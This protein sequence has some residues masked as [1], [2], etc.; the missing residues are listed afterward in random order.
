MSTTAV[1]TVVIGAGAAG[2]H[3]ARLLAERAV[4]FE[5]IDAH[6]RVG[7]PWR[8]RYRSLRL[9]TARR[10]CELPGMRL[11]IGAFEFPTA[12]QFAD[13]LEAYTQAHAFP[14]R[15]GV[16]VDRLSRTDDAFRLVLS[17]GDEVLAERVV[18]AAGAHHR[19]IRPRF[20]SELDATIRQR[21]SLDYIGPEDLAPGPVLV[22]GAA[23][24]G[25]DIALEAAESG[26]ATTLAGRNPGE[27]PFRVDTPLGNLLSGVFLRH[28][29][30][31]T[32]DTKRGQRFLKEHRGHGVN[33]VRN[34][35]RDLADAGVR[36]VGRVVGVSD[37]RPA[38]EDGEIVD[39]TT[40][41]WCTGSLP[42]LGWIDIPAAFGGN[43]LPAHV[44]G[45][46]VGVPGLAFVGL[47]FQYSPLSA[48]L[49][50]MG[51]D[52]AFVVAQLLS[53]EVAVQ[54][55]RMAAPSTP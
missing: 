34:H 47:P 54:K 35:G 30:R 2:L 22:V 24:S 3:T 13:Y 5:V 6:P 27:V 23:N 45:L 10:F 42:D 18:V 46:A 33:R 16:R 55:R 17:T 20:A 44:R 43:G 28:L 53:K 19:P 21:H 32:L 37:G 52:A 7:D 1:N 8:E 14:L 40:V 36:Q 31:V 49:I 48:A 38:L 51:R 4:S 15:M 50:G 11:P 12:G 29:L 9:F 26:H 41:V 39:A 25:T